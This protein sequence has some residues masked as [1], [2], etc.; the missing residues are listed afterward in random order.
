[1]SELEKLIELKKADFVIDKQVLAQRIENRMIAYKMMMPAPNAEEGKY[2]K[3][4][5]YYQ[6]LQQCLI[7][8]AQ[9]LN[10]GYTLNSTNSRVSATGITVVYEKSESLQKKDAALIAKEE[11]QIYQLELDEEKATWLEELTANQAAEA[12]ALAAKKAA[13]DTKALQ[14]ELSALLAK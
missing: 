1:M 5:R 10:E 3:V 14:A 9:R 8:S 2:L 11:K 13:D 12:V 7:D 4:R 6:T